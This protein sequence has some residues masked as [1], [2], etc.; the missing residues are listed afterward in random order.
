MGFFFWINS[1]SLVE[2]LGLENDKDDNNKFNS[3]LEF[4]SRVDQLYKIN[5]YNCWI[6]GC[7]YILTL[8]ISTHQFFANSRSSLSV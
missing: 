1:V 6:A 2:D 3:P 4:Y 5:A 8:L 7:L